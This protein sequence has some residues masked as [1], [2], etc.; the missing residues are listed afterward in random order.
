[1][2]DEDDVLDGGD[3]DEGGGSKKGGGG[4]IPKLLK[5]VAIGLGALVFIVT[6]VVITVNLLNS[7]GKPAQAQI[8]QTE[9]YIAVKPIYSAYDGIGSITTRTKDATPYNV[10]V[11]PVLQYDLNDNS[12]QTELI[13]RKVELQDFFRRFFSGKYMSEL[14][15]ENEIKLKNEIKELINTQQLDKARVRN[16]LF[17]TFDL[18]SM[19]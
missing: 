3:G 16:V 2:A 6:V 9:S 10:A 15:P 5:F 1:M 17:T 12:T 4:L 18:Y 8:P 19:E 14:Q 13:A 11:T 7:G